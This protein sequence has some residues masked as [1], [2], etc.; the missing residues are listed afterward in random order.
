V[1]G[2]VYRRGK[3]WTYIVD[4]GHDTTGRRRQTSK[5]GF[6]TKKEA[7]AALNVAINS[8]QQGT[9][10]EPTAI[11]V[12]QFL[13]ER[14]LPAARGT[15]R[16]TTYS[17]YEM[18]VRCYLAPAFGR[19][20]RLQQVNPLA[21]NAFYDELLRGWN[22]RA[23]LSPAS[24]CR[25]HATLHRALRDAV[26]W[27]LIVRNPAG[28]ADPPRARRPEMKVWTPAQLHVFLSEAADDCHYTRWLFYILTGARRGRLPPS[29][30][31]TS[32]WRREQQP[33]DEASCP[34]ITVWS[35]ANPRPNA[36]GA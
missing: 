27:Q 10:V 25:I 30:G 13:E 3:T 19:R 1:R 2:H 8:L 7:Q 11:T 26:R 24:V 18:H 32:I 12:D 16:P 35:L 29:V 28:V 9:Y 14:R 6:P 21:I 34:L 15:I 4:V 23:V 20:L 36:V 5:G 33:Y 22:G 17:S 31:P